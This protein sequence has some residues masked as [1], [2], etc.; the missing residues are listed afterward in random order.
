[1]PSLPISTSRASTRRGMELTSRPSGCSVGRS[2][3]ECTAMS[4]RL[5]SRASSISLTQKPLSPFCAMAS[6]LPRLRSPFVL[7]V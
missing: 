1:M 6:R 3:R 4:I 2:L 7:M 5:A